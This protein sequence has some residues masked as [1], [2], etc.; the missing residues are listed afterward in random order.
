MFFTNKRMLTIMK[1]AIITG[2][3]GKA[4]TRADIAHTKR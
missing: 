4:P 3:G 2:A 1:S